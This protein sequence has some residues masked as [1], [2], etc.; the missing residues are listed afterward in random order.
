MASLDKIEF[1]HYYHIYNR[2]NNGDA[3][4]FDEE[5]YRYFLSLYLKYIYPVADTYCWCLLKNH[6]HFLIGIKELDEIKIEQLNYSTNIRINIEKVN[7]SKQFSHLFNAYTQAANKK[8]DRTGGVFEEPFRRKLVSSQEYLI[9][10]IFY[11]HNNPVYNRLVDTI[12]DYKWSSYHSILSSK[13]TYILKNDVIELSD[14]LPN[15]QIY[16]SRNQDFEDIKSLI[17]E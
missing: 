1:G 9:K 12:P 11:I 6:F 8:Y 3:I 14:D 15:F 5:N 10:L 7:P 17:L 16:H 13:P 2:G 4:F